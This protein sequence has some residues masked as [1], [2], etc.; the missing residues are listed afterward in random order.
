MKNPQKATGKV[1]NIICNCDFCIVQERKNRSNSPFTNNQETW[2]L[3]ETWEMLYR[4]EGASGCTSIFH[5]KYILGF[6]IISSP[7]STELFSFTF[8]IFKIK[9]L[10]C[11]RSPRKLRRRAS[12][13]RKISVILPL[14]WEIWYLK[15]I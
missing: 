11:L 12:N 15:R 5:Q 13:V 10:R 14:N 8:S 3:L 2:I 7:P 6:E 9:I 1:A 4:L